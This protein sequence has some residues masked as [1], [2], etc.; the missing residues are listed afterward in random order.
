[1]PHGQLA[2]VEHHLNPRPL[3]HVAGHQQA[4]DPRFDLALQKSLE[5]PSA[6]DRIETCVGNVPP[7]RRSDCQLDAL[8]G[9]P[10]TQLGDQQLD[11]RLNLRQGQRLEEHH[12]VD[13]VEKLRAKVRLQLAHDLLAHGLGD[14][15]FRR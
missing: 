2:F 8:C 6:I 9:Q 5:R 11:D 15:P 3:G 1:M 14:L 10:L 12:I 4:G 13:P 7:R